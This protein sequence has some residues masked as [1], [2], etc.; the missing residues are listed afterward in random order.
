MRKGSTV[1]HPTFPGHSAQPHKV[2]WRDDGHLIV[3]SALGLLV[4]NEKALPQYGSLIQNFNRWLLST[5]ST[6]SIVEG[7]K[8][9]IRPRD[10]AELSLETT[11]VPSAIDQVL[12]I[13]L[14]TTNTCQACGHV[15]TRFATLQAVDLAYPRKLSEAPPFGGLLRSSIIRETST[16]AACSHCKQFAP[17]LS[18]RVLARPGDRGLPPVISVN[19]MVSGP[20]VFDVWKD[21]QKGR[22][23]TRYLPDRVAFRPTEDGDMKVDEDGVVY[24]VKVS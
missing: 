20:E 9:D 4:E 14:K 18:Q 6:E 11:S 16:R 23:T 2:S 13:D 10:L 8:I 17:L 7:Q 15:A 12:G 22:V 21:K 1:K 5:I 19:A 3:A 24:E